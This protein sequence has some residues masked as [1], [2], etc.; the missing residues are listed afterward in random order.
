MRLFISVLLAVMVLLPTLS[1]KAIDLDRAVIF[2]IPDHKMEK[3]FGR[4]QESQLTAEDTAAITAYRF[5]GD[6]VKILAILVEWS[7]RQG[8]WPKSTFDSMFFT[9]NAYIGGSIR[10][11]FE[12]VSYGNIAVGGE[13]IDWHNAG[14]YN[15]NFDFESILYALDATID[16]SDFDGNN[17]GAVD[18]VVFVRSGTGEEDSHD[19]NDIWSHAI[20]YS[21]GYGAGPFDG[22]LVSAWNTS[23]EL[24]PLRNPLNPTQYSGLDSLNRIRVFCHELTHNLGLPDLYDY[25]AKLDTTTYFTPNDD[26]DHPVYDW[27][28]MGY[29]GY[30]IFSMVAASTP[31]LCGWSKMKL[32]WVEP[33]IINTTIEDLVIYDIET[34][35]DSSLYMIPID[36]ANGE[37]FLLEYRNHQSSGLFDKLSADFSCYFWPLLTFDNDPMQ[38]GLL[39]T[40]VH[41]SVGST[42]WRINAGSPDYSHYAVA[43]EDAGYHPTR[44]RYYNPEG[45]LTDGARWWYPYETR[46]SATFRDDVALQNEFSPT[47]YP[48]S[49]GYYDPSDI[50]VIVDSIVGDKLYAYIST[51]NIPDMDDDGVADSIDNCIDVYNP[52]QFDDDLDGIGNLCD[53]CTD[54]DGDGFG[55]PGHIANTCPDDNCPGEYNPGQEDGDVNGVGDVCEPWEFWDTVST[56]CTQLIVGTNGNNGRQGTFGASMDFT[57]VGDCDATAGTY[58]Y[59]G[60]PIIIQVSETDTLMDYATWNN[61]SFLW[62]NIGATF[63]PTSDYPEY[64]IFNSYT[65]TTSDQTI[66]MQKSWWAPKQPDS[67]N[68]IIQC[69]RIYSNDDQPHTGLTFGEVI[70]W[71]IPSDVQAVNEGGFE[72]DEKLVYLQGIETDFQGCQLNNSR[73]GGHAYLGAFLND[74][75]N[76]DTLTGPYG[77]YVAD[78]GTYVYPNSGLI[79]E[80]ALQLMGQSGYT[81]ETG[82]Q[83]FHTTISYFH[84]YSLG[85]DDTLVVYT[86]LST[87]E[88][89]TLSDLQ[90]NV[91]KAKKWL[92][93]HINPLCAPPSCCNHDGIRG[94]ANDNGSILVDDLVLLVDYLFKG[95]EPPVCM[96]EGDANADG[97]ILVDDLTLLVDYLFKGSPSPLPC[98]TK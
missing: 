66:A 46:L 93:D 48:T 63:A 85:A 25:D 60:S 19:P 72:D 89:G 7:D 86:V 49:D 78:N 82:S 50:T 28:L 5:D 92:L 57:N 56:G 20:R 80:E 36:L 62:G 76:L 84:N 6:T 97:N 15:V 32:G 18:A 26:N 90:A 88:E 70:D 59:D 94:D 44:N 73:F 87:V 58:M 21:P 64:Q 23:P 51:P 67:C 37:Y 24:R 34:H 39:I 33:N 47:S 9:Q 8:S 4:M 30:G 31:H 40:H 98:P 27:C 29:G 3:H 10:E 68:F 13:V 71:D 41:D 43:V 22:V 14:S 96:E 42:W 81:T 17:D 11:Y 91:I 74:S 83:D 35:Q 79:A 77:A 95:G 38:S 75:C 69:M 54:T 12:E 2:D 45:D 65:F 55:N 16:F 1:V 52:S 61:N 53:E